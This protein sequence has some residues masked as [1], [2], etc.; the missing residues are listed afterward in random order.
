MISPFQRNIVRSARRRACWVRLVTR[1]MVMFL[2]S[3]FST[4]SMRIVVTGSMAME[5]SS[6]QRISGWCERARAMVRRCCWPPESLVPRLSR[7]SF[8]S[9]QSAAWRRHCSTMPSSSLLRRH[10]G[11]A[12]GEGDVVVDAQGQADRQRRDHADLAA[13]VV[14]VPHL[15]HVFAVHLDRA[16][17]PRVRREVDGAVE[18]AQQRGL[19]GLGGADDAEDLV[20][21][22][23]EGDAVD[24]L[25]VPVGEAQVLDF[26]LGVGGMRHSPFLPGAQVDAQRRWR[27]H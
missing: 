7:R 26:D 21:P 4:S 10:A 11:A 27:W 16:G 15:P 17:N 9:S 2:R 18:A 25:L 3:S 12:R 24:D 6:R 19:A 23:V 20:A 14:D 1:M 5:N 13:Q 8:T 22:D